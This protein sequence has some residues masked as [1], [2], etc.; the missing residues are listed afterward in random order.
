M[1]TVSIRYIVDNVDEADEFYSRHLGFR[2][3]MHPDPAF[4]MLSRGDLRLVLVSPVGRD[5]PGGGSRPLP[6]GTVQQPGGWNRFML[7][8][9]DLEATVA[10]LRRDGVR[11]RTDVITGVGTKQVMI[12]D[13]SG[14]PIELFEPIRPE[15]RLST[16]PG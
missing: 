3:D 4:A 6:D 1:S 11:F 7:Q 2:V 9:P 5:H 12:E 8:V 15:A 10:T 16:G 13:P 14:N